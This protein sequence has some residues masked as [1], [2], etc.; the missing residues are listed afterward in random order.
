MKNIIYIGKRESLDC[1]IIS[2]KISQISQCDINFK[3]LHSLEEC[4]DYFFN[5]NPLILIIIENN[6][7]EKEKF[8]EELKGDENFKSLPVL[9]VIKNNS[10]KT[11]KKYYSIGV[12]GFLYD[13]FD[14]DELVLVC[15]STIKNKIRLDQVNSQFGDVSEKNIT[16]AIQLDLLKKFIPV[17]VW[18]K[19]DNLAENQDFEIP[20]EEQELAIIYADL[21]SFTSKAEYMTPKDVI[22]MLNRVFDIATEVIYR[23]SG[24][25]DKFIGDAFLAVFDNPENAL[26]SAIMIQDELKKYN[27]HRK[28]NGEFTTSF[29]IGLHYGR[30]IRGSVGGAVRNDNTLI[31]EPINIAER[32]ESMSKGGGVFASKDILTYVSFLNIDDIAFEKVNIRGRNSTLDA[33]HFYDYY[34][35]NEQ[36]K[37]ILRDYKT[38]K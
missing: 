26:L 20:E 38:K 3:I 33:V 7:R 22:L 34:E 10:S 1:G 28:N 9:L 32:L 21:E 17:T 15:N 5:E 2:Q 35:N 23:N 18:Q 37:N 27:E 14:E 31:G 25:I 11:R 36:L 24:D 13:D 16:K 19:T 4:S 6:I 29:R 30:V 12:E 8:L